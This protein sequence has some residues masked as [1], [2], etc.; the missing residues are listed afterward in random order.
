LSSPIRD[1]LA[2]IALNLNPGVFATLARR[3]QAFRVRAPSSANDL[4]GLMTFRGR[5]VCGHA[6]ERGD[7]LVL[8]LARSICAARLGELQRESE[9][10]HIQQQKK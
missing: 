7:L 10:L 9:I 1:E 4:A 5:E 6:G 8:T 3:R 2:S